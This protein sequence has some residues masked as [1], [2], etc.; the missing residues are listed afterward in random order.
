[1]P[2]DVLLRVHH[3]GRRAQSLVGPAGFWLELIDFL[4]LA[5]R[6]WASGWVAGEEVEGKER[7][8]K[9]GQ[10]RRRGGFCRTREPDRAVRPAAGFGS[11]GGGRQPEPAG[12]ARGRASSGAVGT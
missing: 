2:V 9:G 12:E 8:W 1:V 10:W 5:A 4:F 6:V 3:H 7:G 11:W